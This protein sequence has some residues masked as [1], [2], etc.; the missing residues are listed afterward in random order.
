MVEK[1][2]E[3]DK[4]NDGDVGL[5]FGG[6]LGS[7]ERAL[8]LFGGAP[9]S[10]GGALVLFGVLE[11]FGVDIDIKKPPVDEA[12]SSSL[13][14]PVSELYLA[15]SSRISSGDKIYGVMS[16]AVS[17]ASLSPSRGRKFGLEVV[18]VEA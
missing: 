6:V 8:W 7:F 2:E 18:I 11:S 3:R 17:K 10:Q 12:L 4:C 9:G 16:S 1:L 5:S 15:M 13:L 14:L